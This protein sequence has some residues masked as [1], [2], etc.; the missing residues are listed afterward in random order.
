[1]GKGNSEGGCFVMGGE[2]DVGERVTRSNV[3]V[4]HS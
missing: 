1:M 3:G 4:G 2:G